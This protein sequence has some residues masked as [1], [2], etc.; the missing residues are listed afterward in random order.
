MNVCS[1]SLFSGFIKI[2]EKNWTRLV[3]VLSLVLVFA[4]CN[5]IPSS[6]PSASTITG[7]SEV[8]NPI[9]LIDVTDIVARRIV[10]AQKMG[11]FAAVWPNGVAPNYRVGTGDM[12]QISIWEAPPSVLFIGSS[13]VFSELLVDE[14]GSI[15]L[16]FVG[17][18]TVTNKTPQQ[19]ETEIK[20]RL[21]NKAN[22]PQVL[23]RVM[24]NKTSNVTIVG[25][26]K[27][28]IRMSLT[29]KGER[30]L[31]AIAEAG[32][33]NQSVEKVTIQLSRR[34]NVVSMPLESIIQD[35]TQNIFLQPGDVITAF[36]Q[37]SSFTVLGATGKNEEIHFET[38]GITLAQALARSG[39][40][41]DQRSDAQGI[42]LFRFEDPAAV[43][44]ESRPL[45]L[46]PEGKVPVVYKMD[47][48]DP[49][50]FLVAQHF[51][52]RNKDVLYVA[53]APV[54]EVQKF[55]NILTSS[56]YSIDRVVNI[57]N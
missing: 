10:A 15:S 36:F 3:L 39:G 45:P 56:I 42:F 47:L 20:K 55:L 5:S 30:L 8:E 52:M 27:N 53:N 37:P 24:R 18:V 32:G 34:G 38:Q 28:S 51:P 44:T 57:S 54:A 17:V 1:N 6:G 46:T 29:P 7:Q 25:E 14:Q 26:V 2:N 33:V 19:I 35:P 41:L 16:P 9:L 50:S 21:V 43:R 22:Q 4:G 40:L 13:P 49:R 31:D 12:L 48:K 11:S 23:V